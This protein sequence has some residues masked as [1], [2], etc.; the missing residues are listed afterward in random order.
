LACACKSA[1]LPICALGSISG[2]ILC[3]GI[4]RK[5][6]KA[7]LSGGCLFFGMQASFR[8]AQGKGRG[9]RTFFISFVTG[10]PSLD[11]VIADAKP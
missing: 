3:L 4:L 2:K 7:V 8:M 11:K 5:T 10:T 1:I 6:K 9:A